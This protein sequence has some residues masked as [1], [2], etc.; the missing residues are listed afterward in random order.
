MLYLPGTISFNQPKYCHHK[1]EADICDKKKL[2]DLS[3]W[4]TEACKYSANNRTY[5]FPPRAGNTPTQSKQSE[6]HFPHH[7]SVMYNYKQV[8]MTGW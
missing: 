2:A 7:C 8:L 1:K 4:G 3:S 6:S 5:E